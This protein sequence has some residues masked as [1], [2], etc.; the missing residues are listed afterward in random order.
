VSRAA[1]IL[2]QTYKSERPRVLAALIR[3]LRDFDLAEEVVQDAFAA[4]LEQWQS[5]GVPEVPAAWLLRTARYKAI[6][7]IRRHKVFTEKQAELTALAAVEADL[8]HDE[9]DPVPLEDDRLRLFFTCCHPALPLEAQVAL[10]LRT[11]AGLTTE[12]VAAAF[13]VP[14]ATMAQR[15]VRAKTK[16]RDARIP[17]RVP[18]E[19]ILADRVEAVLAVVYLTFTEGYAATSGDEVIRRELCAEAIR[20]AR[21]LAE[22]MPDRDDVKGLLALMLLQDSRRDARIGPDGDI[23]LLEDQDR[24]RWDRAQ[25]EEGLRLVPLALRA[26]PPNPYA[27]QAAIAAVHAEATTKET[28]DW[29][30]VAALYGVLGRVAPSPVVELNRAVAV[31]MAEGPEA[32]LALLDGVVA[33]GRL[34]EHHL[35]PA[36]RADLLARLGRVS[37]AKVA[38]EQA[39]TL[40]DNGAERRL[41]ARKLSL[42]RD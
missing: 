26:R 28:T 33:D 7:R 6:D 38:Y 1:S 35:L 37:E 29:A 4:A 15:L 27:L 31:A 23:V 17:F 25:I 20:L 34:S 12:E 40:V 32:G 21:L 30:Q 14:V 10:T 36:A 24:A 41:L 19:E 22:M 16:I 39:L 9:D 5:D 2:E 18:P 3:V 11:V 42:L 8:A 13:L